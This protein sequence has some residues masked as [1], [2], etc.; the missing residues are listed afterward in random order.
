MSYKTTIWNKNDTKKI[1]E[2]IHETLKE[3]R[4]TANIAYASGHPV[5]IVKKINKALR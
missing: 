2:E 3:A 5:Q 1:A 4:H